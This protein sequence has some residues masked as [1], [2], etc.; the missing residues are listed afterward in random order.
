[1]TTPTST[2]WQNLK[3]DG[4]ASERIRPMP[5]SRTA[6]LVLAVALTASPAFA[7][8]GPNIVIIYTDDLGYGDVSAYGRATYVGQRQRSGTAADDGSTSSAITGPA[9]TQTPTPSSATTLSRSSTTSPRT[10]EK[11]QTWPQPIQSRS[12][13]WKTCCARLDK[14]AG[15][16]RTGTHIA[17]AE[18]R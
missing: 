13:R 15:T 12:K 10:L 16:D 4:L 14:R 2:S 11:R 1:M 5:T 17:A 3:R 6:L 8:K 18:S 7:Q 9:S